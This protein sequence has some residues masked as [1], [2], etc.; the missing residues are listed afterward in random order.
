MVEGKPSSRFGLVFTL[1]FQQSEYDPSKLASQ[2]YQRLSVV[3]P[4]ALCFS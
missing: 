4:R 3:K 2:H 1:L